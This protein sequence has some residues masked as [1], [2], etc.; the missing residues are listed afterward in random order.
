LLLET[1]SCVF[2][3][4]AV[5]YAQM[6]FTQVHDK[7]RIEL[8]RRIQRGTLSVSLLARQTGFGQSHLSNFL[9]KRRHLSLQ[10][11]DRILDAQHLSLD[12]LLP[13]GR[14]QTTGRLSD[15]DCDVPVV[16]HEA[17]LFEPN[18]RPS[19]VQFL[20]HL[21]QS[22]F[23]ALKVRAPA[24]R[25]AWQRFVGFRA[26]AVEAHAMGPLLLPGALIVIDRHSVSLRP[27]SHEGPSI[28]AVRNDTHVVIRYA[29]FRTGRLVLRP[30]NADFPV[31]LIDV[32]PGA[33][34]SSLVAGRVVFILNAA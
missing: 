34:L 8:L 14:V 12:D 15:E 19:S 5:K 30:R 16:A 31:E 4:L 26:D 29:E 24:S 22:P 27:L 17:V 7:L 6:N 13:T 21:P 20:L 10:A 3:L 11:L 23:I 33:A 9:H 2:L 32:E 25:R 28:F 1:G 18:I